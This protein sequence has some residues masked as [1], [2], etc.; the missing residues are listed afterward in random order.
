MDRSPPTVTDEVSGRVRIRCYD[1]RVACQQYSNIAGVLAGFAFAVL[2]LVA[3][4][5]DPTLP[6]SDALSRNFAAIGFFVVFFGSLLSSF[7]FAVISG[8]EALTPRANN[9][10]FFGGASFSL[11]LGITFWSMAAILRG[12]L[13]DEVAA[14]ADQILPLFLIIHPLYVTSSVLDNVFIFDRRRPTITEY[15]VTT[16]PSVI[17]IFLAGLI[18]LAG[19]DIDLSTNINSFYTLIWAF[20]IMI[21]ASNCIAA[22]FSTVNEEFKLNQLFCGVWMSL[23]TTLISVLILMR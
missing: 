4:T 14:L 7:V 15:F 12:F 11:T 3:E 18:K 22:L 1:I 20:L 6:K 9:M 5:N 8:E 16:G 23:N 21:M 10:A 13:V 19:G 2:I 17:P